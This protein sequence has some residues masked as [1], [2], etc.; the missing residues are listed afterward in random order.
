MAKRIALNR[1]PGESDIGHQRDDAGTD[2]IE[3]A[4][5]G[6]HQIKGMI[7]SGALAP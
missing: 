6:P 3:V 7:K 5:K 4:V 2:Q 1:V